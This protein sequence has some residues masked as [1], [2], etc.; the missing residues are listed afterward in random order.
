MKVNAP[1]CLPSGRIRTICAGLV[2]FFLF[3]SSVAAA[4]TIQT[5]MGDTVRLS[6]Y[7][8]SSQTVYLFLTGPNLPADGVALDNVNFPTDNG[9]FT[10][11]SVDSNN[12]WEYDWGTGSLLGRLDAGTY[13]VWVVDSATTLPNLYNAEYS[14]ISV[15]LMN[16]GL[17]AVTASTSPGT[18]LPGV[19]TIIPTAAPGSMDISAVPDNASVVINGNYQG[20]T[21]LTVDNLSP[22]VYQVNFSRF[23]YYP[24]S[25]TASVESGAITDVN[26]TL[27]PET[28]TLIIDTDPEGANITLDG[29]NVGISPITQTGVTAGNHTVNATLSGYV[30]VEIPVTVYA[31][32]PVNQTISLVRSPI[33]GT[34][35]LTPLPEIIAIIACASAIFFFALRRK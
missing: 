22:G 17:G 20:R 24:L 26:A 4:G 2:L 14:T 21:P 19:V 27:R 9:G 11:V 5:Y 33:F 34:G 1:H 32:L 3:V 6:G 10:P 7:S 13:T 23:N 30:P 29:I 8:Y 35:K 31:N 16:P 25:A 12:H 28:G 18:V 15:V